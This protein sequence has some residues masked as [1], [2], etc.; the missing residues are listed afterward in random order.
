MKQHFDN[1]TIAN[2]ANIFV[3]I[4]AYFIRGFTKMLWA[5]PAILLGFLFF[6]SVK[7]SA[8]DCSNFFPRVTHNNVLCYGGSTGRIVID[9]FQAATYGYTLTAPNGSTTTNNFTGQFFVINGLSEGIY[10]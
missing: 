3:G 6:L 1:T 5:R 9:V 4:R 7:G 8:Q 2:Y 10:S